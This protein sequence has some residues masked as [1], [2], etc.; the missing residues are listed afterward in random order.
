MGLVQ[1]VSRRVGAA[2]LAAVMAGSLSAESLS[3]AYLAARQAILG[4]DF[5][6]AAEYYARALVKD[7]DQVALM[8]NYV[9]AQMALGNLDAA[10]AVARR[11]SETGARSQLAAM[12][13]TA[14]RAKAEDYDGLITQLGEETGISPLV[15]GLLEGWARLGQGSMTDAL[16][17][18]DSLGK[19]PGLLG[20]ALY[21]KAM[22]LASVGDFEAAHKVLD[23]EG[24]DIIGQIR[25]AVIARIE[26][27]SQ[28]DRNEDALT[29]MAESF[30]A[31]LDPGLQKM[32]D[33]LEAGDT[34]P[35]TV[36]TSPSEGAAEVFFSVAGALRNEANDEYTLIY[37][38]IAE[39][40]RP[41]HV[42]ALVISAQM[43]EDM[44]QFDLAVETYKRIPQS[45]PDSHAAELG[46]A[47]ALRKAGRDEAALE[48]LEQLTRSYP[49]LPVVHL[50]LGD[51]L[52]QREEFAGAI[53]SYDKA[54][55]LYEA[56]DTQPWFIYYARAICHERLKHWDAADADFRKALELNPNQ[57]SVLNYLGYS[58][59]E[60]R[61]NLDEALAMIERAVAAEPQSGYIVDSLGWVLYR[62][63]RYEE[64]VPHMER[65]AELM[66]VDPVVNDHLGDVLWKVG[67]QR[68]A[69]FQ[70][71][72]ALSFVDL[73][74]S[75]SDVDPERIRRKLEIGLDRVLEE[76]AEGQAR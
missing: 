11:L 42:E 21:H 45:S 60:R 5:K 41:D 39:Y 59:V 40:L 53:E 73:G 37:S 26:L 65:A 48:V 50:T 35:F 29:V 36:V 54:L 43:L 27:L 16:A 33:R 44:E 7:P 30:G 57:P 34:L 23:D 28:L 12:A 20:F 52:R 15:D 2:A 46:R 74:D 75:S 55:A 51:A 62:L 4:A 67:R 24:R 25:R 63:G 14:E 17:R 19:Q 13:L 66:P 1:R 68:E 3:G 18:F 6:A 32:R 76:E 9:V 10:I 47:D 64:A 72:R 49:D 61:E 69:E 58:L 8:E 22:A 31:D 38:R 70:W 71:R 56:A